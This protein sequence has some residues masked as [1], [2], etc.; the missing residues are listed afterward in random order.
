MDIDR[1]EIVSLP[2]ER[3]QAGMTPLPPLTAEGRLVAGLKRGD[4]A[5]FEEL[6]D[7]YEAKVFSL[8]RGLTRNEEDAQD[9]VQDTFLSVLKNI[10]S[11]KGG[12]SLSTWIYR[13]TV[14]A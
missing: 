8:A 9:A 6:A 10:K 5:A 2:I 11:F 1:G 4:H 13:I 12:S 3:P 7:Q 14:N